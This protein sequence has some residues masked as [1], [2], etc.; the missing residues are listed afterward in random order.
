MIYDHAFIQADMRGIASAE[1]WLVFLIILIITGVLFRFQG[2]LQREDR[3]A[4][5]R[6]RWR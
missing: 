3:K 2:S 1:A 4:R 5:G 6:G